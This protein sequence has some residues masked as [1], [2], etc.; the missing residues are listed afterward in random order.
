VIETEGGLRVVEEAADWFN[1]TAA[2][3]MRRLHRAA[4]AR[5]KRQPDAEL[6]RVAFV[7]E[8]H[9]R[10]V[11]HAHPVLAYGTPAQRRGADLYLGA[12]AELA[13]KYEFGFTD[14]SKCVYATEDA[15]R[16]CGKHILQTALTRPRP[17]RIVHIHPTLV[18]ATG[19]SIAS[20]RRQR[21]EYRRAE[22]GS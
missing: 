12:V 2:R 15:A 6:L 8:M 18:A 11:V 19:C 20:L 16:Y 7:W 14:R 13:S 1:Q 10:G 5:V 4:A 22:A 17:G 9:R 21:F 3:R